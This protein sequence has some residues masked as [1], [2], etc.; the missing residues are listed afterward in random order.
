VVEIYTTN[1]IIIQMTPEQKEQVLEFYRD[2]WEPQGMPPADGLD[3]RQL[4]VVYQSMDF[5][6]YRISHH[7]DEVKKEFR[8]LVRKYT[9][10][11]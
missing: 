10:M 9:G 8:E 3:D 5:A 1:K 2:Y 4:K 6:R 11:K 7:M